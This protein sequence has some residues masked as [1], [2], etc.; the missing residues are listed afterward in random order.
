VRSEVQPASQSHS[1]DGRLLRALAHGVNGTLA[2]PTELYPMF[3]SGTLGRPLGTEVR[4]PHRSEIMGRVAEPRKDM[5]RSVEGLKV[6]AVEW[7]NPVFFDR[8]S[9]AL[10]GG[11]A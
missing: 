8:R 11:G 9:F 3:L 2:Q 4:Q 6:N 5:K 10:M 7:M 1:Q